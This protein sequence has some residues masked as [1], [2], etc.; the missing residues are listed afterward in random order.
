[1]FLNALFEVA[2]SSQQRENRPRDQTVES[3]QHHVGANIKAMGKTGSP[4]RRE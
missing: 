1:M 2:S 4:L 3:G